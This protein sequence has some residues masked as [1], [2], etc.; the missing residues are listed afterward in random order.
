MEKIHD[1]TPA[2]IQSDLKASLNANGLVIS[3]DLWLTPLNYLDQIN[4]LWSS[5]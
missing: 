1:S 4:K 5:S 3:W 2:Q